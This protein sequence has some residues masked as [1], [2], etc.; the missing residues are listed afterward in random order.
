MACSATVS[1]LPVSLSLV[2]IPRSRVRDN[3]HS[4]LR[5][6]LLPSPTFLNVTSNEI[7]LTVFA[8][9]HT[10]QDFEFIA[11]EDARLSREEGRKH[12]SQ[13]S[14]EPVE[15]SHERWNVL[16]IDSHADGLGELPSLTLAC[17]VAT[18]VLTLSPLS[19]DTSGARVHEL[20]APLAAAGISIL[21][22]SSYMSDFI[23]VSSHRC[24]APEPSFLLP[25]IHNELCRHPQVMISLHIRKSPLIRLGS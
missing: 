21:Y 2:H 11:Q 8:E 20:S 18:A 15:V 12:H 3:I 7:E 5:Q 1:L 4:V 6:L 23:F 14:W 22:Q 10:L 17:S 16:Q 24:N 19:I 25:V 9:H 13:E